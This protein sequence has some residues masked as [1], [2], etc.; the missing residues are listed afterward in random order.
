MQLSVTKIENEDL[1]RQVNNSVIGFKEITLLSKIILLFLTIPQINHAQVPTLEKAQKYILQ[2]IAVTGLQSYNEQTVKTYTGLRIGQEI[3]IPGEEISGVLKKLWG[4]GL[5]SKLEFYHA[6]EGDKVLLELRIKERPTLSKVTF[7]GVK[8]RKVQGVIDDTDL[9]KGK[10]ITESL[11]ADT[12]N[13]LE[14]KYKKQG[15]LNTKV[16][17]ATA[18]D[19]VGTNSES[20]VV[21][22]RKGD[23]VKIKNITFE[24]NDKKKINNTRLYNMYS[25]LRLKPVN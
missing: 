12:K 9:K 5:F 16:T 23:K 15:Y 21:N 11:I 19:T 6:V 2:G 14:N 25:V 4:L 10:K 8:K 24:G 17:I 18:K 22:I 1:E 20:M 3:T 7:Y 13:Y